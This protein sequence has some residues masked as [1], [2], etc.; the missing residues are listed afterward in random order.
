MQ[1][2]VSELKLNIGKYLSLAEMQDIFITK[3]GKHVAKIVST[4]V[5]KVAEMKSVFGA[6]PADADLDKAKCGRLLCE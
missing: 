2:S 5:D 3:N 6:I 4:K 1:I